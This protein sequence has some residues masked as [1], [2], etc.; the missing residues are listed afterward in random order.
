MERLPLIAGNDLN[1]A[2]LNRDVDKAYEITRDEEQRTDLYVTKSSLEAV[3]QPIT[4][5]KEWTNQLLT[6]N[7]TARK[8]YED[9]ALGLTRAVNK[10]ESTLGRKMDSGAL[11]LMGAEFAESTMDSLLQSGMTRDQ[12]MKLMGDKALQEQVVAQIAHIAGID[13]KEVEGLDQTLQASSKPNGPGAYELP[14]IPV[15]DSDK[16]TLTLA[17]DTLRSMANVNVYLQNHPEQQE[18]VSVLVALTQGPKGLVQLAIFN[19]VSET[20]AGEAFNNKIAEYTKALGEQVASAMEGE[21]LS[22]NDGYDKYLIGGGL[23]VTA[24]LTGVLASGK[25][26][27]KSKTISAEMNGGT[28]RGGGADR[29]SAESGAKGSALA[30]K[31]IDDLSNAGKLLDPADKSGQLSLAG[32]ALQKHGS[33][34]G[35]AFPGVKGSPSEINAQG[36]KI[37]DDILNNPATTVTYKDTGRFGKVMDVIAPDGRGLRYDSN[38][39]FIGLLEPPKP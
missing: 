28:D 30:G 9:A 29:V 6:Y 24:V 15:T 10:I 23:F 19:A 39:K 14:D 3:S 11:S 4:T 21:T 26:K 2:S 38:G 36:Q 17:Q 7:E 5:V 31:N 22:E 18:A 34:E 35:S 8:N 37:A 13:F 32:R 1:V 33:R 20:P 16:E 12:A 27:A 25:Y